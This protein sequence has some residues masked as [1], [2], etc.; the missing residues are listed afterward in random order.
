MDKKRKVYAPFSLTSEAGVAQTP[1]EGYI[2]VLQNVYP[3]VNT[4]N[5]N[6]N[7]KW[8][9][10]KASDNEFIGFTKDE[11]I[12]NGAHVLVPTGPNAKDNRI[13]MTGFDNIFIALKVSQ[14][15]AFQITAAMGPSNSENRFANLFP[16]SAGYTLRGNYNGMGTEAD[17]ETLF[18]EPGE[19]LQ[20]DLWYIFPI[21]GRLEGQKN[22]QFKVTNDTGADSDIEFAYLRTVNR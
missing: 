14:A 19:T 21:Q 17:L 3:T 1:V 4:G 11:T 9:G 10:V 6:E 16:V 2:D 12:G 15:G 5:I 20:E 13:D 8:V 18:H 7:G 22:L